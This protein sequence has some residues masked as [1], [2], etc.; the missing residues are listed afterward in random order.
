MINLLFHAPLQDQKPFL[1][2]FADPFEQ[3]FLN[4]GKDNTCEAHLVPHQSHR[5]R[6]LLIMSGWRAKSSSSGALM[7]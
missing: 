4:Y 6:S 1:F 3:N 5:K 2:Q 7:K